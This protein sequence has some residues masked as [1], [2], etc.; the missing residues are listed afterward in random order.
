MSEEIR[1]LCFGDS[2][3]EGMIDFNT[4]SP[5]TEPLQEKLDDAGLNVFVLNG[6]NSGDSAIFDMPERLT[7]YLSTPD[8]PPYHYM[9]LLGGT[10]DF[11]REDHEVIFDSLKAMHEQV[12]DSGAIRTFAVTIPE[13]VFE[14]WDT[15]VHD[16]R[17][18]L[19]KSIL[20]LAASNN[21]ISVI[22]LATAMPQTSDGF[23]ASDGLHMTEKGYQNF[24]SVVFDAVEKHIRAQS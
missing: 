8:K 12:L 19:N 17:Q 13:A 5:Y 18:E 4:F 15:R 24:A 10:N 11:G 7:Q 3:T 1:L 6:G 14:K 16:N 23:W 22:D 20:Q 2:L 9:V 21:R